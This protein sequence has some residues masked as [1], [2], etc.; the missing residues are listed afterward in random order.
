[1]I[2][3]LLRYI[4]ILAAAVVATAVALNFGGYTTLLPE[5]VAEEQE[6]Q[7]EEPQEVEPQVDSLT[8][9][10]PIDSLSMSP[11]EGEQQIEE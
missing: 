8:M 6:Q 9:P 11:V 4:L 1:M 10:T 5:R 7:V 2:S 3:K